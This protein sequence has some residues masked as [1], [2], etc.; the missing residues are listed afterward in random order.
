M[1][2]DLVGS[3]DIPRAKVNKTAKR[4]WRCVKNAMDPRSGFMLNGRGGD[5]IIK[6]LYRSKRFREL[7]YLMVCSLSPFFFSF[8]TPTLFPACSWILQTVSGVLQNVHR[9]RGSSKKS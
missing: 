6:I 7:L 8:L 9:C 1:M 5:Q 3:A 4:Q 2:Q